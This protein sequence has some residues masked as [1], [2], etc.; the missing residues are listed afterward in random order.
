MVYQRDSV[1]TWLMAQPNSDF[2]DL[3]P[4]A[5]L[6]IG[7]NLELRDVTR[8]AMRILVVEKTM[9]A[10]GSSAAPETRR[11]TMLGRP[12]TELPDELENIIQ[13]A[14]NKYS[15]RTQQISASLAGPNVFSALRV[16]EWD[17]L[18]QFGQLLGTVEPDADVPNLSIDEL[19]RFPS[20]TTSSA[21]PDDVRAQFYVVCRELL[22]FIHFVVA[23]AD[24]TSFRSVTEQV[25]ERDRLCYVPKSRFQSY[26]YIWTNAKRLQRR[27]L[28]DYWRK[29]KESA[30]VWSGLLGAYPTL[31][32]VV[33][34]FNSSCLM[35]VKQGCIPEIWYSSYQLDLHKLHEQVRC[36]F[37]AL[38]WQWAPPA[39]LEVPLGRSKH[40]ALGLTDEEFKYLP[41][42]AGGL[43]D[44]TGGVFQEEQVPDADMGPIGP[45]PAYHTG[46][47]V[48][49]EYTD[50]SS[51]IAPS[52]A[53]AMSMIG[54]E[55]D[56][57]ACTVNLDDTET[58]TSGRSKIAVPTGSTVT[59][60][61]KAS[62]YA[63]SSVMTPSEGGSVVS[64][65]ASDVRGLRLGSVNGA[66]GGAAHLPH[67][68]ASGSHDAHLTLTSRDSC[69]DI[70][71]TDASAISS[72]S[73]KVDPQAVSEAAIE[74]KKTDGSGD[75]DDDDDDWSLPFDDEDDLENF[76]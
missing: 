40:L 60:T 52:D 20:P 42:W 23:S 67:D 58:L 34:M 74:H 72:G 27:M 19:R 21:I 25:T 18:M 61:R 3:E 7:W 39:R 75:M 28:T 9:D 65:M 35:A 26:F 73:A 46:Y 12:R 55:D 71:M 43:D 6:R 53:P 38:K 76:R 69:E 56:F 11:L 8:A 70:A 44:G 2:I 50:L 54:T 31:V 16:E 15:E 22:Q 68:M 41:L 1:F 62:S 36:G 33:E 48:M 37:E 51:S 4:E 30:L 57:D 66:G 14:T 24:S 13:H 64:A 49:S 59:G 45:G 63:P 47:S 29:M 17:K 32:R 10:L 5:S